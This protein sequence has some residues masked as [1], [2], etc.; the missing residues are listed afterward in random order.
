MPVARYRTFLVS[1]RDCDLKGYISVL[2][3]FYDKHRLDNSSVSET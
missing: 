3:D 2:Y 1:I